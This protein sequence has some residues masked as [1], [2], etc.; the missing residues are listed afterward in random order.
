MEKMIDEKDFPQLVKSLLTEHYD[1]TYEF[2]N[3]KS[4]DMKN[5]NNLKFDWPSDLE[6]DRDVILSCG[7]LDQI[8]KLK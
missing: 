5:E 1:K 3:K 6:L 7:I 8:K 2:G 4:N